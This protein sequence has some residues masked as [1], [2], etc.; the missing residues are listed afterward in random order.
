MG[1]IQC[2]PINKK[3]RNLT[4]PNEISPQVE[5]Q[6]QKNLCQNNQRDH[7]NANH[8]TKRFEFQKISKVPMKVNKAHKLSFEFGKFR[9]IRTEQSKQKIR[10]N[11]QLSESEIQE[12]LSSKDM[13]KQSKKVQNVACQTGVELLFDLLISSNYYLKGKEP[14]QYMNIRRSG[15]ESARSLTLLQPRRSDFR[16]KADTINN[17]S[18]NDFP[19]VGAPYIRKAPRTFSRSV[20]ANQHFRNPSNLGRGSYSQSRYNP[21]LNCLSGSNFGWERQNT[22]SEDKLKKDQLHPTTLKNQSGEKLRQPNQSSPKKASSKQDERGTIKIYSNIEIRPPHKRSLAN[23]FETSLSIGNNL[24]NHSLEQFFR[25]SKLNLSAN[26]KNLNNAGPLPNF[27]P[28]QKETAS[29]EE[30]SYS[31]RRSFAQEIFPNSKKGKIWLIGQES[32]DESSSSSSSCGEIR[33]Q[34]AS[35]LTNYNETPLKNSMREHTQLSKKSILVIKPASPLPLSAHPENTIQFQKDLSSNKRA[36]FPKENLLHKY[37]H[38]PQGGTIIKFEPNLR[39]PY[40]TRSCSVSLNPFHHKQN[41]FVSRSLTPG[42]KMFKKSKFNRKNYKNSK[43][44]HIS[45]QFIHRRSP[46]RQKSKSRNKIS[47]VGISLVKQSAPQIDKELKPMKNKERVSYGFT[48]E[49]KSSQYDE[50][51]NFSQATKKLN[52]KSRTLPAHRKIVNFDPSSNPGQS[53]YKKTKISLA[54]IHLDLRKSSIQKEDPIEETDKNLRHNYNEEGDIEKENSIH[55]RSDSI[56]TLE[57]KLE[58]NPGDSASKLLI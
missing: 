45:E 16:I 34:N 5:T 39:V 21:T 3:V 9:K 13:L 56:S 40:P 1:I 14:S 28:K 54:E 12:A 8:K 18:H 29:I 47:N 17:Q 25:D 58:Q 20:T 55:H 10:G 48:P 44:P 49:S 27:K 7:V 11:I 37:T 32:S 52:G 33:K 26:P 24:R 19:G 50:N 53:Y 22:V 15:H 46:T 57:K 43:M 36:S 30:W 2:C 31:K 51:L 42:E 41:L 38:P 6:R 23:I 4:P 35:K